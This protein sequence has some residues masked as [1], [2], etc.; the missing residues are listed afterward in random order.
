MGRRE[1]DV[2]VQV[3]VVEEA[4]DLR[5]RGDPEARLD[6]AAEHAAEPE[7]AGS[8]HHPNGLTDPARLRELDVDP[9]RA[10]A[11]AATSARV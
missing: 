2:A 10:L 1:Q 4:R 6:H 11:Q 3:D 8:V 5:A 9:V 7:R